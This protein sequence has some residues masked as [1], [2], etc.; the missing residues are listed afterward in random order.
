MSVTESI[1]TISLFRLGLPV[2]FATAE[3][4]TSTFQK[5]D[6]NGDEAISFNEWLA[7]SNSE[8]ISKVA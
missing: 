3:E 7:F 8:I 2:P 1:Q 6:D 5:M 4:R